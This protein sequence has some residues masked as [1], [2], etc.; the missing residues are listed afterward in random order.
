MAV[1][2]RTLLNW[3]HLDGLRSV[4]H[5]TE[6]TTVSEQV[7]VL[8]PGLSGDLHRDFCFRISISVTGIRAGSMNSGVEWKKNT[9]NSILNLSSKKN[10]GELYCC[11]FKMK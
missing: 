9:D 11:Y 4:R 5:G 1:L 2:K 10:F 3:F 8:C 7:S 6:S